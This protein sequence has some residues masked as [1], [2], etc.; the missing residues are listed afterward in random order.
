ALVLSV[1]FISF[2]L[3]P[4]SSDNTNLNRVI[5]SIQKKYDNL[6]AF[7]ADFKQV[8]LNTN[9]D[10]QLE[11]RG[12]LIIK[13]GGFMRWDYTEPEEKLFVC[14]TSQCY[15]Y[16][17]EDAL[18]QVIDLT[19]LDVSSAPMLFFTGKGKLKSDFNIEMLEEKNR[20]NLI[21]L[22]LLP[23]KEGER[24]D[25]MIAYIDPATYFIV[26]M[27]VVDQLGN[28]TDYKFTN[29]TEKVSVDE[30]LFKFSP[31]DGTEIVKIGEQ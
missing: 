16:I 24:F 8:L 18:A 26:Q 14:N 9:S 7:S 3:I 25:Y 20:D 4:L 2:F 15:M 11:E 10:L 13:K 21:V 22:R 6:P 23:K 29:I 30:S 31:P 5:D 12:K 19:D 27:H 28:R 1:F 17:P